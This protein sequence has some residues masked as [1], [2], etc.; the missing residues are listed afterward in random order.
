MI[1]ALFDAEPSAL[2]T[3][4]EKAAIAYALEATRD[5]QVSDATFARLAR[6][7]PDPKQQVELGVAVAFANFNNRMTDPFL[8]EAPPER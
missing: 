3:K 4:E 6:H 5:V 2:F 8:V 7:F 1:G